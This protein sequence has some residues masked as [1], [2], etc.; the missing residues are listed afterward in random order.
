MFQDRCF[1]VFVCGPG[2]QTWPI[3]SVNT[4]NTLV[5]REGVFYPGM[6]WAAGRIVGNVVNSIPAAPETSHR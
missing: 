5:Q 1:R 4:E 2:N 3:N 6:S